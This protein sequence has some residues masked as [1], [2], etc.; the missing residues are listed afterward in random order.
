MAPKELPEKLLS[1]LE[2]DI[3][4][5]GEDLAEADSVHC[6]RRGAS[7]RGLKK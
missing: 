4:C 2:G 3:P 6:S 1:V 7:V 5:E